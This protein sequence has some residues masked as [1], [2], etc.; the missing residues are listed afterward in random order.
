MTGRVRAL[1][2]GLVGAI[3]IVG[4]LVSVL[5]IWAH[6]V[7]FDSGR[8]GDAVGD[9]LAEPEVT[10]ALAH[11]LT[12]EVFRAV[13]LGGRL[14][15]L[16]PDDLDPLVPALV[17]GAQAAVENSLEDALADERTRDTVVTLVE[18]S[19][20]RLMRVLQGDGLGDGITVND[21]EVRVD[22]LPLVGLGLRS[23]QDLGYLDGVELPNLEVGGDP[24][25]ELA[26][27]EEA[28]GRDLPDDLGQLTVFRG[29]AVE[30]AGEAVTTAQRLLVTVKRAIVLVVLVTLAAFATT[31]ALARR[32]GR[33][34][35]VLALSSIAVLLVARSAVRLVESRAPLAVTDPGARAAV[36]ATVSSLVSGLVLLLTLATVVFLA[37]AIVAFLRGDHPAA[38]RLRSRAGSAGGGLVALARDHRDTVSIGAFGLAVVVIAVGGLGWPQFVVALVVASVGVWASIPGPS[39]S[40]LVE[41]DRS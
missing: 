12:V 30:Q 25:A 26:E 28:L 18:A 11:Q 32:R 17:G 14:T 22:L 24:A 35:L 4:L 8:V 23:V 15:A 16:V 39:G 1:L 34:I 5:G 31:L 7:V 13:D 9:A 38:V 27:L 21:D 2:A 10:A 29:R 41:A 36:G 20:A 6:R 3:A 19:H 40:E 33:A 37:T